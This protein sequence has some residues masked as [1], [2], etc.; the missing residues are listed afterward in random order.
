[1]SVVYYPPAVVV[2]L[3]LGGA[4]GLGMWVVGGALLLNAGVFAVV[5]APLG[6]HCAQS[7]ASV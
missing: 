6:T 5:E 2:E 7:P 4:A 1:M 3:A